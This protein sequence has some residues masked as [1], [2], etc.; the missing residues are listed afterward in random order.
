MFDL[1]EGEG[2]GRSF[3]EIISEKHVHLIDE[4]MYNYSNTLGN[5]NGTDQTILA[6]RKRANEH[7]VPLEI[8]STIRGEKVSP[9][10]IAT[11]KV[12]RPY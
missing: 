6:C 5:G 7:E 10:I 4:I 1:A 8:S 11:I 2:I 3:K 9:T 12:M